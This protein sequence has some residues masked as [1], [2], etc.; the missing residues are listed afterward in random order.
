[1]DFAMDSFGTIDKWTCFEREDWLLAH[2]HYESTLSQYARQERALVIS[3]PQHLP[4]V[5]QCI[6]R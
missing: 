2:N 6:S 4:L 1:M 3:G 5:R